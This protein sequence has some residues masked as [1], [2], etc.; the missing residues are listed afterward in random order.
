MCKNTTM[1]FDLYRVFQISGICIFC[2]IWHE[3]SKNDEPKSS[4]IEIFMGCSKHSNKQNIR[5]H[6]C[7]D[8]YF[9]CSCNLFPT[10]SRIKLKCLWVVQNTLVNKISGATFYTLCNFWVIDILR[11]KSVDF[12]HMKKRDFYI[13]GAYLGKKLWYWYEICYTYA[14]I[15]GKHS[16]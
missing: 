16:K 8:E 5:G 7:P 9:L 3:K 14:V 6:I 12:A 4:R 10:S 11:Q 13:F 15:N 1:L 2:H